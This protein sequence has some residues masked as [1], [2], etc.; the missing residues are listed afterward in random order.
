MRN[1]HV[2]HRPWKPVVF[3][4]LLACIVLLG[5]AL[6]WWTVNGT[7]LDAPVRNDA[8]DYVSYVA[9]LKASGTYSKDHDV[10]RSDSAPIPQPD[11][12]RPP[13]YPLFL[14]PFFDQH[15]PHLL[16][17]VH[18]VQ[19]VQ[20]WVGA[21]VILLVGLLAR[22]ALGDRAALAVALLTALSPHLVVYTPYLLTETLYSLLVVAFVLAG[23]WGMVRGEGAASWISIAFSAV[24]LG[25][26]CLVRPTLDQMAWVLGALVLA[27][28]AWRRHWGRLA[29]FLAVFVLVMAPWWIRNAGLPPGS[30]S[31]AIAITIQQGSYPDMMRDGDP[32]TLGYPYRGDPS[33]PAA[34]ASVRA[35]L[36]DL[37]HKF[38][39]HPLRMTCWF[40]VGKPQALFAWNEQSGWFD[41]F[42]YPVLDSPWLKVPA[43][44]ALTSTIK[45]LHGPLVVLALLGTLVALTPWARGMVAP[46]ALPAVRVVALVHAYFILVHLAALPLSR[47]GV[48]FR[49]LTYLMA[50]LPLT[51]LGRMV[52]RGLHDHRERA[53]RV[54]A[55]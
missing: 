40:L 53:S 54:E 52:F 47:Y 4:V 10:L 31:P 33:A 16:G 38:E 25:M 1:D 2:I 24:L 23:A 19:L 26:A 50:V 32:A 39:A 17:F 9:N 49:P 29:M 12:R 22:L 45:V 15:A 28:P 30:G 48:P 3:N 14:Y 44:V 11:A 21:G 46:R 6:R 37:M 41:M 8:L 34:E 42:E 13:G 27:V 51:W 43:L 5:L 36:V 20:V 35:A 7:M 55:A 18:R